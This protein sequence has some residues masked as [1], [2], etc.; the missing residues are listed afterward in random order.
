VSAQGDIGRIEGVIGK[1]EQRQIYRAVL[2]QRSLAAEILG[3][4][5]TNK[6]QVERFEVS[7]PSLNEIFLRVVKQ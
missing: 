1:K 5:I 4:L 7:T 3:Q 6:V 2:G